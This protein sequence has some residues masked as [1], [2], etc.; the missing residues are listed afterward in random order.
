MSIHVRAGCAEDARDIAKVHIASWHA[1]YRGIIEQSYIDSLDLEYK[2]QRWRENLTSPKFKD[3]V[4]FVAMDEGQIVGFTDVGSARDDGMDEFAELYSI[5]LH[6]DYF[7]QG[8]GSALFSR[9]RKQALALGYEKMYVWVLE[10]NLRGR[11]FY[12]R[13][14]AE[15]VEGGVKTIE[16]DGRHYQEMKYFWSN[17]NE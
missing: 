11:R 3:H 5:Y 1:A 17:L 8:A 4:N 16:L 15:A 10:D 9:A 12:E 13:M 14:G 2:T 7:S 6:P